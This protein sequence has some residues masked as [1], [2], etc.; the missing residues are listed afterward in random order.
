TPGGAL[1]LTGVG[2]VAEASRRLR[3][4]ARASGG[5]THWIAVA[6]EEWDP[7]SR[8]ALESAALSL[9][10]GAVL[11]RIPRLLPP[12]RTP[13]QWRDGLWLPCG[14]IAGSVRLYERIA[15]LAELAASGAE[16]G[17]R[18]AR[19]ILREPGWAQFASDP[20]GDA[21]FPEPAEIASGVAGAE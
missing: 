14:T 3:E 2:G 11:V 4:Q 8:R 18:L 9:P 15:E 17:L 21:P 10:D 19:S 20:T 5:R 1:G 6:P 16:V 12:P 13:A 7:L